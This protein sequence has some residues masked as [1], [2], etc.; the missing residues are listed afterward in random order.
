MVLVLVCSCIDQRTS[1]SAQPT[2]SKSIQLSIYTVAFIYMH[3]DLDSIQV[4]GL[5]ERSTQIRKPTAP[6]PWCR[7]PGIIMHEDDC[8]C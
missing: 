3:L 6:R 4:A 1:T 5:D 8:T 7:S 2:Y